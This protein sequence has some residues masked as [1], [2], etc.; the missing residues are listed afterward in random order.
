M[1][2]RRMRAT[3]KRDPPSGFW[4]FRWRRSERQTPADANLTPEEEEEQRRK[5]SGQNAPV[6]LAW[7][8][9]FGILIILLYASQFSGSKFRSVSSVGVVT[10]LSCLLVGGLLG[11]LFGI[12]RTLQEERPRRSEATPDQS[13]L[14]A[15]Y[16]ANTNLEQI[17]DWLTK[18]LVG[19]GLTQIG[20]ISSNAE[21]LV[22]NLSIGL[23]DADTSTAFAATLLLFYLTCGFLMGYLWTRLYLAS[24]LAQADVETL[25]GRISE[26]EEKTDQVRQE[27]RDQAKWDAEALALCERALNPDGGGGGPP[28]TED[29]LTQALDRASGPIRS[30]VFTRAYG[31]R[32]DSW[33][34]GEKAKIERTIPV[35][36]AL[37]QVDR[38]GRF[39]R[40]HAQLG[41]A[42]KDQRVPDYEEAMQELTKAIEIRNQSPERHWWQFYEFNR[43]VCRIALEMASGRGETPESRQAVLDDLRAAAKDQWVM[44]VIE[45][46]AATSTWLTREGLKS[47]DLRGQ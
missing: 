47:V 9:T 20:S 10:A 14:P 18:I 33:K 11:F 7:I 1:Q 35:F 28:P 6:T 16:L 44:D 3:T 26:V 29:E 38:E 13:E 24:A 2:S 22:A 4:P 17:S 37:V 19:L 45:K 30:Q 42:L 8:A 12:P 40:N 43:A 31:M 25:R 27:L 23:G 15:S 34:S 5:S 39:H 36:R 32:H 21:S 46:D 41:Y